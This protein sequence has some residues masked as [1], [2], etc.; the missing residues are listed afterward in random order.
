MLSLAANVRILLY[1]EPV[2]MR[3]SFDGLSVLVM[4][5]L[6]EN[7]LSGQLFVFRNRRGDKLKVLY[8]DGQGLCLFYKRLEKGRFPILNTPATGVRLSTREL[9]LLLG[10]LSPAL[11]KKMPV[12]AIKAVA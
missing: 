6:D 10:G 4:D 9:Q 7:P 3:R 8:S 1:T 5:V 12:R 11:A 2:D